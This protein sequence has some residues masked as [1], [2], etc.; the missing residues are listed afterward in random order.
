MS[1]FYLSAAFPRKDRMRAVRVALRAASHS[2]CS[3][4]LDRPTPSGTPGAAERASPLFRAERIRAALEDFADIS[5]CDVFVLFTEDPSLSQKE[6]ELFRGGRHIELG[7]ARGLKDSRWERG[8]PLYKKPKIVLVGPL[9]HVTFH[10]EYL[11]YE[12]IFEFLQGIKPN[13]IL[14]YPDPLHGEL[15][16]SRC[17][18]I[19]S[20][21]LHPYYTRPICDECAKE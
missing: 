3:R 10:Q 17:R 6:P 11:Q 9:E 19:R 18:S 7:Y 14:D 12:T 4:W 5:Q 15:R 2:V 20:F 13:S 1:S 8:V 21:T 16:C